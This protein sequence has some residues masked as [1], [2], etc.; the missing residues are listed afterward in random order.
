MCGD[1]VFGDLRHV[2]GADLQ[3]DALLAGPDHRGVDRAVVVLLRRRNVILETARHDRPRGVDDTERLITL[4]DGADD[5]A[6]AEN[7]R[8]L[9]ETDSLALHL[10]PD[11]VRALAAA[12]HFDVDAAVAELSCELLLDL[13]DP[14]AGPLRQRLEPLGDHFMRFGVQLTE[15]QILELLAHRMHAHPR[16]ERRIDIERLLGG[17][18]ARLRWPERQRAHIVQPVGKLDQQHAHV[19]GNRQQKLAQVLGLLGFPRDEI[20]PLQFGQAIDQPPDVV[21]EHA[22]DLGAGGVG[23]L[24]RVV[25]QRRRDGGVV[26][27]QVGEDRRHFERMREIRIAGVALLLAVRLHGVDI[28]TVEQFLVRRRVVL[29]DA[30]D[31]LVLPHHPRLARLRCD[32]FGYFRDQV[33]AARDRH[34]GSGLVLHPRQVDWRTRHRRVSCQSLGDPRSSHRQRESANAHSQGYHGVS[35]A[36]QGAQNGKSLQI[37][38]FAAISVA[39]RMPNSG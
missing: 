28:G 12:Q 27:L 25:Q 6:E 15:C 23:I 16:G 26:E 13:A 33:R 3:F 38:A 20:Q 5:D 10:A 17:A 1:A 31:Q 9:L 14:A 4:R 21:A 37:R 7:I 11:R 18:A 19:V 34:P 30:V 8:E 32:L 35:P 39:C 22:I 36:P 29:L 24:D 2:A